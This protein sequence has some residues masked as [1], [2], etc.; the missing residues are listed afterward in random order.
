M[1]IVFLRVSGS[2]DDK[3]V[4]AAQSMGFE[5][6][7][8]PMFTVELVNQPDLTEA[9]QSS[10]DALICTSPNSIKALSHMKLDASLLNK[11][12]FVVGPSTGESAK[13][14]GFTQILGSECGHATKLCELIKEFYGRQQASLLFLAGDKRLDTIVD[15]LS[16]N[17]SLREVNVYQTISD[18]EKVSK[19]KDLLNSRSGDVVW[20]VFF[21][22]SLVDLVQQ[23]SIFERYPT[24]K[25]AA[26]GNTTARRLEEIGR[27]VDAVAS[28]PTPVGLL[29][30]IAKAR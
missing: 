23:S 13:S 9:L 1:I 15:T 4:H 10:F 2:S 12:L 25:C 26:I 24:V 7:S 6:I 21:S 30:E 19:L 27:A 29:Q 17:F 3:Y 22:P 28:T 16:P 18:H 8:I 20:L 5:A 11:P 14:L